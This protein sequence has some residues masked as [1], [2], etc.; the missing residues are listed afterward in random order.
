MKKAQKALRFPRGHFVGGVIY[1]TQS[2]FW[3]A[4]PFKRRW[5]RPA[6]NPVGDL[7]AARSNIFNEKGTERLGF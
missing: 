5:A 7:L 4:F 2:Y 1:P 3:Y 6:P